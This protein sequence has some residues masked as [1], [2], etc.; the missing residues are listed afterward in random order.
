MD[1]RSANALIEAR[2][3]EGCREKLR[4][5]LCPFCGAYHITHATDEE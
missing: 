4:K 5:Y 2:Y 1:A 3:A